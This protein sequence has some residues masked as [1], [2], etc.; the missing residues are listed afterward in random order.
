MKGN[1]QVINETIF[2]KNAR[3]I[4]TILLIAQC[5]D[6]AMR[7]SKG[8]DQGISIMVLGTLAISL[9]VTLFSL[10][11]A[12]PSCLDLVEGLKLKDERVVYD[13]DRSAMFGITTNFVFLFG[14]V[15]VISIANTVEL[16]AVEL[17]MLIVI[18]T[19]FAVKSFKGGAIT[20]TYKGLEKSYDEDKEKEQSLKNRMIL[21]GIGM[22]IFW[23]GVDIVYFD[24]IIASLNVN[25]VFG[26]LTILIIEMVTSLSLI[27]VELK[28]TH[29]RN[30]KYLDKIKD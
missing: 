20:S 15:V 16:V 28:F 25:P 4:F 12:I 17:G 13:V 10:F 30:P 27:Y 22:L 7:V 14:L 6:F 3:Y 19:V 2:Q 18:A 11:K 23:I 21:T 24:T 5:I 1:T 29:G 9:M 26:F 8:A